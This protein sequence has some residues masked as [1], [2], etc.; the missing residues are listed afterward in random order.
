MKAYARKHD[1]PESEKYGGWWLVKY[2]DGSEKTINCEPDRNIVVYSGKHGRNPVR[3]ERI[4]A[5]APSAPV[6]AGGWAKNE[7]RPDNDNAEVEVRLRDGQ[8][9]RGPVWRFYWGAN[10]ELSII[11]WRP[12]TAGKG[13]E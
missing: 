10:S 5:A 7:G 9:M 8:L 2:E 12:A 6:A 4:Q 3:L 11:E 1:I 13:G